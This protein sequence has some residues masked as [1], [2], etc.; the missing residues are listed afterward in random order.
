MR[1]DRERPVCIN[2]NLQKIRYFKR[3][4]LFHTLC[5]NALNI[6]NTKERARKAMSG[7]AMAEVSLQPIVTA[8]QGAVTGTDIVTLFA[9]GV[10][11]SIG[12]VLVWFGAKWVYGKF[13]RAVKG[14]R[15]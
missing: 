13:V 1:A 4:I 5:Y 6:K 7:E 15:G 12:I 2:S 9:T 11:A 14:G 8:L 10:T 3:Y